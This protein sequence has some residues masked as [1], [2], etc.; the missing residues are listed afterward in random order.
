MIGKL[1]PVSRPCPPN[2]S[3]GLAVERSETGHSQTRGNSPPV[4][5]LPSTAYR[6]LSTVYRL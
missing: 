6:L 2:P 5:R 1:G 3:L 4:Y